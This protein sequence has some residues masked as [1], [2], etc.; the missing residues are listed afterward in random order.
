[1]KKTAQEIATELFSRLWQQFI[2]RVPYAATYKEMVESKGG[3][4]VNDHIAFR[5]FNTRTGE[6]PGGILAIRH[7]LTCLEYR[8]VEKYKFPKEKLSAVHFEHPNKTLPKI[9][10]SQL[11]VENLPEWVQLLIQG[12]VKDTSYLL[13]DKSIELLNVLKVNGELPSE[14]AGFLLDDLFRYFRRPW[15]IP[16]KEDVLKLNDVSQYA[17]WVMLHGNSVNHFT[18]LINHQ[19]VEDWPDLDA[20][21][22]AM[23]AAGVPMKEKIEGEK[24]NKLRQTA[25][26]AVKEDVEVKGEN[27]IENIIWTYAYYELAERGFVTENGE[28]KLFDG[29]LGEQAARLF[30]LTKTRDN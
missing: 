30:G 27:G 4:V 16:N 6:Q 2:E 23:K 11:E 22:E 12:A 5:T 1:M 3:K 21:V 17:A 26:L 7:I 14:A 29:F 10:V 8:P 20:T 28:K 24:G 15:G 25:T 18:A 9:F 13:S 19:D